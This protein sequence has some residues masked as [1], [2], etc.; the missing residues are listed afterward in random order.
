MSRQWLFLTKEY[1]T[2]TVE[3]GTNYGTERAD[4]WQQELVDGILISWS[5]MSLP[6]N[7]HCTC[8]RAELS[9]DPG[10]NRYDISCELCY[11]VRRGSAQSRRS[12][13]STVRQS[14]LLVCWRLLEGNGAG[15]L[16]ER[17]RSRDLQKH[18]ALNTVS[19]KGGLSTREC[20]P[21]GFHFSVF[22]FT[23]R[24]LYNH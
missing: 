3:F 24:S 7:I 19:S 14:S 10:Q 9:G 12:P 6:A 11:R 16:N 17:P 13:V 2:N 1:C 22:L 20:S 23:P 15:A 4:R 18:R 21:H 5:G 8:G